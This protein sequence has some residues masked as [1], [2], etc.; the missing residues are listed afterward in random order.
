MNRSSPELHKDENQEAFF[1][2]AHV[3]IA[4]LP[5]DASSD[6]IL[7][8]PLISSREAAMEMA[9]LTCSLLRD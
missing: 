7:L 8:F 5:P 3:I 6:P 9:T 2:D 4:A 1:S